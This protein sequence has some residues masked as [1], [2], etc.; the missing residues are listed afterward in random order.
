ML[1]FSPDLKSIER[2]RKAPPASVPEHY[3]NAAEWAL[4]TLFSWL[5]VDVLLWA[6]SLLLSE[7]KLVVVGSESGMVSC[8]VM[9]LLVLLQPLD[10]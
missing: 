8:A 4:P 9:G 5:P 10:W 1:R 3:A 7:A 2:V 6:V